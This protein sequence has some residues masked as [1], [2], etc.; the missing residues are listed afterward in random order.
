VAACAVICTNCNTIRRA[1]HEDRNLS[2]YAPNIKIITQDGK[3]TPRGPVRS[4][5]EKK[6]TSQSGGSSWRRKRN[7]LT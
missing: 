7:R 5:D 6:Y 1:I 2:T 4:E 3:V